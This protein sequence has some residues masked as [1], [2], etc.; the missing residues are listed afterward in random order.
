M[1]GEEAGEMERWVEEMEAKSAKSWKMC[2][3]AREFSAHHL[4]FFSR[5]RHSE[6]LH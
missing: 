6:S 2:E 3:E 4:R 5:S 1:D